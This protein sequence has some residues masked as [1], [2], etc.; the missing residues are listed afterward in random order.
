MKQVGVVGVDS[1]LLRIID[2]SYLSD[3]REDILPKIGN[4]I[5]Y[6]ENFGLVGPTGKSLV[7]GGFGGDGI[8]PV[9][10]E[11]KDGLVQSL[12]VKFSP[13]SGVA[14]KIANNPNSTFT[15]ILISLLTLGVLAYYGHTNS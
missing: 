14:N 11:E 6:Q 4:K 2:P 15:I 10:V 5:V 1:G 13:D 12:I 3:Y 7:V 9:Y 8:F